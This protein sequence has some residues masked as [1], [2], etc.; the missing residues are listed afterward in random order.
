MK[1]HVR[2]WHITSNNV[3]VGIE[4]GSFEIIAYIHWKRFQALSYVS[5]NTFLQSYGTRINQK[6]AIEKKKTT[7]MMLI[8]V[9]YTNHEP[10]H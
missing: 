1:L 3:H 2:W 6:N 8:S 10:Q 4:S 7:L 9:G 5:N